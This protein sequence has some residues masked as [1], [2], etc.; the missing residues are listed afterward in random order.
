MVTQAQVDSHDRTVDRAVAAVAALVEGWWQ[1]V[2]NRLLDLMDSNPNPAL[3]RTAAV[4]QLD[5]PAIGRAL[6]S[7]LEDQQGMLGYAPTPADTAAG[8]PLARTGAEGIVAENNRALETVIA[9]LTVLLLSGTDSRTLRKTTRAQVGKLKS[10]LAASVGDAVYTTDSA[11]AIFLMRQ[12]G[13]DRFTYMGG[14]TAT[15]RDFCVKHNNKTYTEREIRTIWRN[16]S[17]GGKKPG[18]PFVTRGGWNCR[19]YWV[20]AQGANK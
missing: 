7:V 1:D 19:H 17:W 8:T 15:S 10:R 6:L 20:P 13:V 18:D 14:T 2:E 5:T 16:N 12:R 11:Y 9:S 3:L 4:A